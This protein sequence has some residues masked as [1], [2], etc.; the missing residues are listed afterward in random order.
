MKPVVFGIIGGGWRTQFFLRVARELPEHFRV[1][2][3]VVRDSEK[4]Q[5]MEAE[6][7]VA[8]YRTLD[9]LLNAGQVDFMVVSVPWSVTPPMLHALAERG[10]PVLAETPPAP[11]LE[12]LQ[13]LHTLTEQGAKIQVAEQYQFQPMHAARRTVASSGKLGTVTQVRLSVAHGYHGVS[14]LR[15]LLGVTDALPTISAYTFTA[16]LIDGPDRDL[17]LEQQQVIQATYTT[18]LLDFGEKLGVYD[19]C[20]S[21]YFSWILSPQFL[22]RGERGEI[23]DTTVRY[24]EDV[25]TPITY[26]LIRQDTGQNGNLEGLYH[27]GI[28]GGAQWLYRNPFPHARLSDDEIAVAT[29]LDKMAQYVAGG[30]AFYT[31]AEASQDHYLSILINQAAQTKQPVQAQPQ[32]WMSSL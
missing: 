12:G 21:Q 16:P 14:L 32:V 22:V 25:H 9:A 17:K 6:W 4:G 11:D 23:H 24:L 15:M 2:G 10:V 19:F 13:A 30:P 18:A 27:K 26:E 8:T 5:R 28:L 31:L 29:C 20:G 1:S 7:D 3:V